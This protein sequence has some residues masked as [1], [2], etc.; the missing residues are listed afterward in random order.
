MRSKRT[1]GS[2]W[3][4][5]I[6][7]AAL[8]P[9]LVLAS[10]ARRTLQVTDAQIAAGPPEDALGWGIW[11]VLVLFGGPAVIALAWLWLHARPGTQKAVAVIQAVLF[12]AAVVLAVWAYSILKARAF[13]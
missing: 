12:V 4:W 11:P 8:L 5:P 3:F 10:S 9:T 13:E 1:D 6:A 7:V 2:R